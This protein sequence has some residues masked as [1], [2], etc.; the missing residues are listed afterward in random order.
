MAAARSF[1]IF[2]VVCILAGFVGCGA[3][4][5]Q[6][7]AM[8]QDLAALTKT[9]AAELKETKTPGDRKIIYTGKLTLA[10]KSLETTEQELQ[11]LLTAAEGQLAEFREDR[12]TGNRR[13]ATWKVRIPPA[14]FQSF[15]K[16]VVDLGI[17]EL[18]E[19]TAAD[20]T[21]EFVDIE[22]RLK[23]KRQLEARILKLLEE[24]AGELKDIVTVEN[25]LA[26]VREEIER[27][28][29]RLRFL[30]G[31]IELST[32]TIHAFEKVDYQPPTAPTFADRVAAAWFDS[33][34]ALRELGEGAA[35]A[36]VA[37]A[38]WAVLFGFLLGTVWMLVL[39]IRRRLRGPII[40]ADA[41][42]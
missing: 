9:A 41:V 5:M 33:L 37:L 7:A 24:K 25:E 4:E 11:R 19:V 38:P 26:R 18:H 13:A 39:R 14:K 8:Q 40:M 42:R 15:V 36:V 23:N 32:V 1:S 16:Q 3:H 6:R 30:A 28:E 22:A 20:V 31:Q 12:T 10:V 21:E 27:I 34:L 2:V 35:I 29:G 17:P